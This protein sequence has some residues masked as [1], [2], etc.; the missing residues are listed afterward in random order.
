M[1]L[2]CDGNALRMELGQP[3]LYLDFVAE[4]RRTGYKI[5]QIVSNCTASPQFKGVSY[6]IFS[7][8]PPFI[9]ASGSNLCRWLFALDVDSHGVV[10][11]IS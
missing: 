5:D 3:L 8:T 9:A 7:A 4:Q 2:A 10:A 11:L 1:S 6:A